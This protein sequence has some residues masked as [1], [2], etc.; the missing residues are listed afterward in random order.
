MFALTT[1][2][3]CDARNITFVATR[4]E[5]LKYMELVP[6]LGL[7]WD[8]EWLRLHGLREAAEAKYKS[9][10]ADIKLQE[11]KLKGKR[12]AQERFFALNHR[13]SDRNMHCV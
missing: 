6:Q 2:V 13:L 5:E 7:E 9:T 4:N 11:A 3:R 1:L 8:N 10:D 12:N